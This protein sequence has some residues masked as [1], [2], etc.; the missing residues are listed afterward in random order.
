MITQ[1]RKVHCKTCGAP[2]WLPLVLAGVNVVC[3]QCKAAYDL[4]LKI[5][6]KYRAEGQLLQVVGLVVGTIVLVNAIAR[7]V[8][9]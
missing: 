3:P 9:R 6:P 1:N 4:G 7:V 8:K 2:T 5:E